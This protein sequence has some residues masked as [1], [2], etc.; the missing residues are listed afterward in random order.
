MRELV[1]KNITS[2]DHRKRDCI[3]KER[4][5]KNGIATRTERRC[6]Y[7]VKDVIEIKSLKDFKKLT[8][9]KINP[10]NQ[11]KRNFHIMRI[12]DA[13]TGHERLIC[14]ACGTI[15]AIMSHKMYCIGFMH[16]FKI[17]FLPAEML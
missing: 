4:L 2:E 8:K 15:Y 13:E 16:S 12:K 1:L 14:K 6:F 9:L 5:Y 10:A 11:K 7:Y 3:I 17:D